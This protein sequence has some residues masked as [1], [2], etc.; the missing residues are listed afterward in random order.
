MDDSPPFAAWCASIAASDV[1][2]FEA[3]FRML[4]A[5]LV[6]FASRITGDSTMA[7]DL[8]QE[9]FFRV[10]DR[11]T[12]LDPARSIR[13][14]LYRSVR[15]LAYN[16][17]RDRQVRADK[18]DQIESL[19]TAPLSPDTVTE[20][21]HLADYLRAWID[22]LPDRQREAL[23]LSRFDGLSHDEIAEAMEVSP[24]TVNNHLVAAL[25]TLRDYVHA[26]DPSLLPR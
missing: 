18:E 16:S 8:V 7:E 13:A 14:L 19:M 15:N 17:T 24:R 9:A 23:M 2:A 4:H 21:Q 25:K 22:L 1:E 6:R 26:Y 20:G 3:L 5:P 12:T 10:W 11:R